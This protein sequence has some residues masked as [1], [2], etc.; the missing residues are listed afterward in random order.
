VDTAQQ[1]TEGHDQKGEARG[2]PGQGLWAPALV[3]VVA[4][5]GA[6]ELWV[7]RG[8]I[9]YSDEF[10]WGINY[11]GVLHDAFQQEWG[12]IQPLSRVA[13][14]VLFSQY[15]FHHYLPFRV[16]G[17]ACTVVLAV[18]MAWYCRIFRSPWLGI[19]VAAF[20]M[21]LG[22][23]FHNLLW[24]AAGTTEITMASLPVALL[25]LRR[26]DV[27]GDAIAFVALGVG[28]GFAAPVAMAPCFAVAVLV[29]LQ[30]RW[31]TLAVPGTWAFLYWLSGKIWPYSA[32]TPLGANLL[33]LPSYV[34]RAAT[35]AAGGA[36][37]LAVI[38]GL[39]PFLAFLVVVAVGLP[40][41]TSERRH[42]VLAVLAMLAFYWLSI[43]ASR[44]Q[45][46]E[47]AAP[48][49]IVISV[50]GYVL[51]LVELSTLLVWTRYR[52]AVAGAL[53]VFALASN[54]SQMR[55]AAVN[56]RYQSGVQKAELAALQLALAR[57][58]ANYQPD[59][60]TMPYVS[61][62]PYASAIARMGSPALDPARLPSANPSE[63]AAADRVLLELH[64][65][66]VTQSKGT[67]AAAAAGT[68]TEHGDGVEQASS[69][70]TVPDGGVT[71]V[72]RGTV[73]LTLRAR[74][75]AA[76][77]PTSTLAE[78]L[79]GVS[80]AIAPAP[81]ASPAPWTLQVTGDT[82]AACRA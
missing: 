62:G 9:W 8:T 55:A 67:A 2:R 24:P 82:W 57:A 64:G 72:N 50:V 32:H 13:F 39:V 10:R 12:W 47:P 30:R 35:G 69:E 60:A 41:L 48:R 43:G 46:N 42:R 27:V 63:Q 66:D 7:M 49:Y 40:R 5:A 14:G 33:G 81:D 22:S 61:A 34:E 52:L 59:P 70:V 77:Y 51:I 16:F 68:C 19:V 3:A 36:S 56:F 44:G 80:A 15:G 65:L 75:F 18:A 21:L 78:V 25:A 74:R 26:R 28:V 58:P 6:V 79:P 71:I 73:P 11:H 17:V 31:L 29:A 38:D 23:S 20:F 53:V 1:I 4:V 37:G 54:A 76:A 45:L